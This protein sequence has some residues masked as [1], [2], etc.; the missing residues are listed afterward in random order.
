[1]EHTEAILSEDPNAVIRGEVKETE[2]DFD[3]W[4]ASLDVKPESLRSYTKGIRDFEHW[5]MREGIVHP[6]AADI[7]AYK[8]D[9]A[10]RINEQTGKPFSAATVQLYV[11]TV[12][13]YFAWTGKHGL[14]PDIAADIKTPV[15]GR[16]YKKECLTTRQVRRVLDCAQGE[17]E[18]SLRDYAMLRLMVTTGLRTIEVSRANVE[19]LRVLADRTVLYV[20]GKGRDDRCEYVEIPEE[21]EISIRSYL[22]ARGDA[23]DSDPLFS[24][25][26]KRGRKRMRPESVSRIAKR[27]MRDAGIDD[28]RHTAHSLRHTA[29][30]LNLLNGG[31]LEETKSL[32]R[33]SNISA[34][35]VYSHAI[36]Q[37]GNR[38]ASRIDAAIFGKSE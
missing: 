38:S 9:L 19:D 6:A 12:K 35:L 24:G 25:V 13:R 31:T 32:L 15:P 11:G 14:Y 21:L 23:R 20:Q 28:S 16:A 5:I 36:E 3:A 10:G 34:T 1:M 29:A 33:H 22:T 17:D 18:K 27:A 26:G 7:L 4:L 30:T 8:Q 2:M 37:Q